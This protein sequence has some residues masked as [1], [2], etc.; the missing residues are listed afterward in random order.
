M[1]NDSLFLVKGKIAVIDSSKTVNEVIRLR[2]RL[3]FD[4][5]DVA[6]NGFVRNQKGDFRN[7]YTGEKN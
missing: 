5:C 6:F 4:D 2:N 3:N 7:I 1:N